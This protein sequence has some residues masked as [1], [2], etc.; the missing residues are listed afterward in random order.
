MGEKEKELEMKEIDDDENYSEID[1]LVMIDRS[2][3]P[4][5]PLLT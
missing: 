3:D 1:A 2:S 4:Y 5:T